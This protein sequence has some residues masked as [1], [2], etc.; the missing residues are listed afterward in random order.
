MENILT[1]DSADANDNGVSANVHKLFADVGLKNAGNNLAD[2]SAEIF[3][4]LNS[5]V[6]LNA[7]Y[8]RITSDIGTAR[9]SAGTAVTSAAI[10]EGASD[11]V[12]ADVLSTINTANYPA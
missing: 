8:E 6:A 4:T 9:T 1:G 5:L 11:E 12:P 2:Q 7:A 10:K 3:A